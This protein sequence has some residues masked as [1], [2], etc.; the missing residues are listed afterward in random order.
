M[1]PVPAESSKGAG[2]QQQQKNIT[3]PRQAYRQVRVSA[4]AYM[5]RGTSR[6]WPRC[7][8][9]MRWYRRYEASATRSQRTPAH[10]SVY[11]EPW[12]NHTGTNRTKINQQNTAAVI[13]WQR[14]AANRKHGTTHVVR[15]P[16]VM[17]SR[18]ARSAVQPGYRLNR[19]TV[20]EAVEAPAGCEARSRRNRNVTVNE[21]PA[22]EQGIGCVAAA[23]RPPPA[24][25]ACLPSGAGS[26]TQPRGAPM[27]PRRCRH[28]SV[29]QQQQRST[30]AACA[31]A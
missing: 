28:R 17:P 10:R 14:A 7:R 29:Q 16:G 4:V 5:L 6:R 15:N 27:A 20:E 1:A 13:V 19:D 22:V 12:N 24:A 26:A 25:T 11:Q 31:T 3:K 18:L 21:K 2:R 30:A 8:Q 23:K 9:A